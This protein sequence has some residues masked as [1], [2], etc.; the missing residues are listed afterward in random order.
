MIDT[1]TWRAM[2]HAR[3]RL[4]GP[5][6]ELDWRILVEL[7]GADRPLSTKAIIHMV[8]ATETTVKRHLRQ[9]CA[10]GLI[11]VVNVTHDRRLTPY[12]LTAQGRA[13]FRD[14]A[15]RAA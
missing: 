13:M 2:Y 14:E 15:R 7:E 6:S 4:F 3:D 10:D 8:N 12:R 1:A 9:L 5:V 11:A